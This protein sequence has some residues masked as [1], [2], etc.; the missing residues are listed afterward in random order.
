MGTVEIRGDLAACLVGNDPDRPVGFFR[1]QQIAGT[2]Q[3]Q[4]PV[5]GQ[6]PADGKTAGLVTGVMDMER[7]LGRLDDA[8]F[9][10]VEA[11]L[12]GT[13]DKPADMGDHDLF[14]GGSKAVF[15]RIGGQVGIAGAAAQQG[16]KTSHQDR[17]VQKSHI[18]LRYLDFTGQVFIRKAATAS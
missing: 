14:F 6:S 2:L 8:P 7:G 13:L 18:A 5:A 3:Q 16:G 10:R 11:D 15:F 17:G 4:D 12:P 9:I 1:G